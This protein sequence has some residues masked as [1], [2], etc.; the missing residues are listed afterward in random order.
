VSVEQEGRDDADEIEDGLEEEVDTDDMDREDE[1]EVD[2]EEVDE[3]YP[4]FFSL[5]LFFLVPLFLFFFVLPGFAVGP[6]DFIWLTGPVLSELR[7]VP[8]NC[9]FVSG[10]VIGGGGSDDV[11]I[12]GS[13]GS[14]GGRIVFFF[15][16]MPAP[17]GGEVVFFFFFFL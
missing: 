9:E 2:E 17:L 16:F 10:L 12:G 1:E 6:A 7:R 11:A 15:G 5:N 3:E 14:G 13:G 4:F 8:N